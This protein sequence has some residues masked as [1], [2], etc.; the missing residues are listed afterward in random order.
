MFDELKAKVNASLEQARSAVATAELAVKSH[1]D[2]LAAI[3]AEEQRIPS[4]ADLK[5]MLARIPA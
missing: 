2:V 4:V 5:A 3:E 1:E